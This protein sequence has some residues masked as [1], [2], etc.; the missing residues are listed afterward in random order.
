[1]GAQQEQQQEQSKEREKEQEQAQQTQQKREQKP[2]KKSQSRS[3]DSEFLL[4]PRLILGGNDYTD[5]SDSDT[6]TDIHKPI[7]Q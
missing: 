4:P 3:K 5:R 7:I 1:M 2:A 6:Y